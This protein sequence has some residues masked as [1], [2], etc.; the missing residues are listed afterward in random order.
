MSPTEVTPQPVEEPQ[1]PPPPPPPVSSAP[2]YD[3]KPMKTQG[4]G[5][6]SKKCFTYSLLS[7]GFF[8][9]GM[10]FGAGVVLRTILPFYYYFP[11]F[12]GR[13]IMPIIAFILHLIGFVFGIV[14]RENNSKAKRLGEDHALGK[15]GSVFGVFGIILNII[16]MVILP[17][18]MTLIFVGV[19]VPYVPPYFP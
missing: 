3:S 2:V 17:M 10:I 19:I 12:S 9:A 4:V 14:S 5:S 18:L 13:P 6:H 7:I 1:A 11:L 15:V 16:P 8:V